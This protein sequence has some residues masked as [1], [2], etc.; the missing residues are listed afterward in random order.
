[1]QTGNRGLVLN[2]ALTLLLSHLSLQLAAR[3][4]ATIASH[5]NVAI[6]CPLTM[7][8]TMRRLL[9]GSRLAGITRG[10][11]VFDYVESVLHIQVFPGPRLFP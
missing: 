3:V 8:L 4:R 7:K 5:L 9:E 1:M 11:L 10:I 2:I 6:A